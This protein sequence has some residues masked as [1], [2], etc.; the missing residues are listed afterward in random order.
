M[1]NDHEMKIFT[2]STTLAMPPTP[3]DE[4][5]EAF[6]AEKNVDL[7]P[8]RPELNH[9]INPKD[10]NSVVKAR[11]IKPKQEFLHQLYTKLRQ[12]EPSERVY[13]SS[14]TSASA[15]F[16]IPKIDQAEEVR[17]LHVSVA[18]NSNT[19]R[20]P[21]N[22]PDQSTIIHTISRYPC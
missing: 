12:E 4:D 5:P 6:P 14:D 7:P 11:P 17:F 1:V 20:E 19:I 21:L 18:R 9:N 10:P 3:L 22:I 8:L 16:I 2:T 15:M 13:R